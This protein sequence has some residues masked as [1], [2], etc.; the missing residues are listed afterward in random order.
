MGQVVVAAAI[1]HAPGLIGLFDGAPSD[2]KR[3]VSDTFGVIER[4][5]ASNCT[6]ALIGTGCLSHEPGGS[7]H[8]W[9][10]EDFDHW[11]L[12]LLATADHD[13][14]FAEVTMDSLEVAGAGGKDTTRAVNALVESL[15]RGAGQTVSY[16]PE[17]D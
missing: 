7:R 14:I 8:F 17:R 9:I 2:S 3:V 1:S 15:T 12:D 5:L 13:E 11:F 10:D 6:V 4:D 16:E